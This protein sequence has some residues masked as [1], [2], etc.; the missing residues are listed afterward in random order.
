MKDFANTAKELAKT[1]LGILAL[2][3]VFVYGIAALLFSTTSLSASERTPLI[4]FLVGF[5]VLLLFIFVFLVTRHY[6]KIS[7]SKEERIEGALARATIKNSDAQKSERISEVVE[8]SSEINPKRWNRKRILWVDDRPENNVYE[9]HAFEE[10]GIAFTLALSTDQ[11]LD[12]LHQQKFDAIISDMGRKEGPQEGYV[13]LEAIQEEGCLTPFF[14]YSSSDAW[15]HKQ[16][17][18]RHGAQDSCGN[19]SDLYEMVTNV[20]YKKNN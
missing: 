15:E 17:A 16:E 13:L 7:V 11:A 3:L 12:M 10:R 4:Y 5:P 14:I 2:F 8:G 6:D 18:K 1:P 20:V 19:P 9:R